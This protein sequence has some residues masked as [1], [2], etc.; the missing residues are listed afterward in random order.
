LVRVGLRALCTRISP[1]SSG[2]E[3]IAAAKGTSDGQEVFVHAKLLAG[4]LEVWLRSNS[5]AHLQPV[6]QSLATIMR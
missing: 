2:R 6:M 5:A 1:R 4:G 3:A